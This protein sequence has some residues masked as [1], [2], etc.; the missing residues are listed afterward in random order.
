MENAL[1]SAQHQV[2]QKSQL[3]RGAQEGRG[4]RWYPAHC[5]PKSLW[6]LRGFPLSRGGSG[7]VAAQF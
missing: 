2:P 1:V 4:V 6:Y 5:Q 7:V 3:D